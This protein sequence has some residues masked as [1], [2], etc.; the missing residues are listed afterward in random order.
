MNLQKNKVNKELKS[1]LQDFPRAQVLNEPEVTYGRVLSD[2]VLVANAVKRGVTNPLFKEIRTNSPFS[3]SQWS[4]FLGINI[5]T[6]QRY[7]IEK[8]HVYKPLQS[9]KIFELAEV[10]G[11]GNEVFDSPEH[12]SIWLNTP[13]LA[14]AGEKPFVYLDSSYGIAILLAELSRIEHGIF[15]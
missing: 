7:N 3:D 10:V 12:F 5:R 15:V 9:E 8:N 13:N 14:F 1:Y 6:L 4:A 11:K 2:K